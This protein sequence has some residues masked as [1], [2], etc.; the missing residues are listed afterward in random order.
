MEVEELKLREDSRY[1]QANREALISLAMYGLFF[2]W[3]YV[4]AYGLGSGDPGEY[5]YVMGF[6]AWFFYS[7]VVGY[8]GISILVWAVVRIF[9]SDVSIEDDDPAEREAR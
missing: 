7:C 1:R 4:T 5:S 3:W 2:A 8:V 6:P 9:F